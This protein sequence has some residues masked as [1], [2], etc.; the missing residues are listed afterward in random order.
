MKKLIA[1][2][3]LVCL[4]VAPVFNTALAQEEPVFVNPAVDTYFQVSQGQEV[5]LW[6]GWIACT[7]G[8]ATAFLTSIHLD[9]ELDGTPLFTSDEE[10][11]EFW[12]PVQPEV[13]DSA[14]VSPLGN[15]QTW[16]TYWMYSIGSFDEVGT[17]TVDLEISLD[18]PITDGFDFLVEDGRP[19][20]YSRGS[21]LFPATI[22]VVP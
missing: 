5:I 3:L 14:C 9:W 18:H 1:V 6:M 4:T 20:L 22:E 2:L 12:L 11:A 13:P 16:A 21:V 17:H 8:L 15:R 7:R 19:D 10:T